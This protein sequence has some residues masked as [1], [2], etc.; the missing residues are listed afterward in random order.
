M[1]KTLL[2][3]IILIATCAVA[4]AQPR[5]IGGRLGWSIG[6]SYQHQIGEKN[7]LQAD[8]DFIGYG[9]WGAQGTV[10]FNWLIPLVDVSAGQLNLYPGVG[11]GGGYEWRWSGLLLWDHSYKYHGT[12][13]VGVAGMIGIEWRFKFPLQLSL[14]YRPLIGV[15]LSKRYNWGSHIYDKGIGANFYYNG[16]WS[17]AIAVGVRYKFGGK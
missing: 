15:E 9:W 5:A 10:T 12:G 2:L 17:S 14:E 16:L 8:I 6:P 11:V 4:M 13:F 1:K 7:M 3:A